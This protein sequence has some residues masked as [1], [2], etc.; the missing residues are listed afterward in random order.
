MR[1]SR[2]RPVVKNFCSAYYRCKT[3]DIYIVKTRA[4]KRKETD[5]L[6]VVA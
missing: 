3:D 4:N 1:L 5:V 2:R 6:L